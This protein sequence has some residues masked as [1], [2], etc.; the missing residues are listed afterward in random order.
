MKGFVREKVKL[1]FTSAVKDLNARS[2][3]TQIWHLEHDSPGRAELAVVSLLRQQ[4]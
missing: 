3:G 1:S 2:L 4:S